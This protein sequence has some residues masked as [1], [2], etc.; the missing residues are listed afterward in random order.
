MK[1]VHVAEYASG[2]VATYLRNTISF[3]LEKDDVDQVILIN[4]IENSEHINFDS[5]KFKHITFDYS[6][7]IS[8][9][10]KLLRLRKTID[11]LKPDI[12]HYHSSFAGVIRLTYYLKPASYKIVYCAHGWSFVQKNKSR[13]QRKVYEII[14][15]ILARKTDLIINISKSEEQ[16]ALD[17][18]LPAQ[19]MEL[20]YNTI[21]NKQTILPVE[22]PFKNVS[23][24]KLLF[25]G[26]FDE[27]KGL[28]FLLENTDFE[29]ENIELVIIGESVLKNASINK[30]NKN[31]R[32]LGWKDNKYIDS[33]MNF[34]DAVIIPS[35]WEG[36]GLVALEAMKNKK[37]VI[38]SDAGGLSEIII[39]NYSGLI[40]KSNSVMSL[41]E[42][43]TVFSDMSQESVSQM[44]NIGLD[45]LKSKYNYYQLSNR[46]MK[47][48]ESKEIE[49]QGFLSTGSNKI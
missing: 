46:L 17:H 11:A 30:E 25:V 4:S 18:G 31:V 27:Q 29:T 9:V 40:F 8:N 44:G 1:I 32:F 36:F 23:T 38:A 47:L 45:I 13:F 28:N 16:K 15:R 20:I 3:Q 2:G 34:C 7:S 12:V 26:R 43:L 39:N 21:P 37:M 41:N 42:A 49:G 19:K 35:K 22:N 24:K 5:E 6:R 10:R 14:E 33:Y 48:Y